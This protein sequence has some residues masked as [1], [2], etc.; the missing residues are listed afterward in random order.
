MVEDGY[1][2][3]F[4]NPMFMLDLY[5]GNEA[6]S[7]SFIK[8]YSKLGTPD[9]IN[10][11]GERWVSVPI[12]LKSIEQKINPIF[13]SIYYEWHEVLLNNKRNCGLEQICRVAEPAM[14]IN[15]FCKDSPWMKVNEDPVCPFAAIM[16]VF[17]LEFKK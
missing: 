7:G 8:V 6:F 11:S 13:L 14:P 4:E 2:I 1:K 5:R 12:I 3:R 16:H 17:G 15:G 10:L 9:V